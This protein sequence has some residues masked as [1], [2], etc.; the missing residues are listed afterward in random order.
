MLIPGLTWIRSLEIDGAD[1]LTSIGIFAR[2]LESFSIRRVPSLR[3][4]AIGSY[5][6]SL[7]GEIKPQPVDPE[8]CRGWIEQLGK[9]MEG[10]AA[11]DLSY[12]P[13]AEQDLSPLIRNKRIRQLN[14]NGAGVT[15]SQVQQLA[16]MKRLESLLIPSTPLQQNELAWLLDQ[17][18]NLRDL[19]ADARDLSNFDLTG[20][21]RLRNVRIT[22]MGNLDELRIV[23]LTRLSTCIRLTQSPK[24]LEIRNV[25]SLRGLA[26]EGPWPESAELQGLRDLEWFTG[27]GEGINDRVV[28][29]VLKCDSMDRLTLAY[30]S[31]SAETLRRIGSLNELTF[32]ALPGANVNDDVVEHWRGLTSLWEV[33]LDDTEISVDTIGWLSRMESLRRLSIN[34]V[35]LTEAAAEALAELQQ[36]SELYLAGVS[37]SGKNLGRLLQRGSLETLDLS[38]W[39]ISD[40]VLEILCSDGAHLKHLILRDN[41]VDE[42]TFERL[43]AAAPALYVDMGWI[44]DFV[45]QKSLEELHRRAGALRREMNTGWRSML[46]PRDDVYQV[47]SDGSLAREVP[48]QNQARDVPSL[49]VTYMSYLNRKRFYP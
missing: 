33:N 6:S 46:R 11:L 44:P 25:P 17:F 3:K 24:Q 15:Y 47:M 40:E 8:R 34:R 14:L 28:N 9:T 35:P 26:V 38:G 43:L 7:L 27:G 16:G 4:L 30:P 21:D 45:D 20:R 1:S 19:W 49:P 10:P 23:D 32:L 41:D 13:L 39:E 36:V 22:P 48:N 12:L 37:M 5:L 2:D 42:A 29:E 18:P 31:V